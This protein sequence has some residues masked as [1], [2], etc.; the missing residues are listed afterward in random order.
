MLTEVYNSAILV[1]QYNTN[2]LQIPPL[3]SACEKSLQ[4][5]EWEVR[6]SLTSFVKSSGCPS[7]PGDGKGG[8][9]DI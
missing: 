4:E 3:T 5:E 9:F 1:L 2:I 7:C 8:P 6:R